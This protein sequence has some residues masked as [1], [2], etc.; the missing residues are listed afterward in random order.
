MEKLEKEQGSTIISEKS[1]P[2]TH[3]IATLE[4]MGNKAVKY[5]CLGS[6]KT[7]NEDGNRR[8]CEPNEYDMLW[9]QN[10]K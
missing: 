10:M 4:M 7:R 6:F 2:L 9:L 8:D 1:S 3:V 5:P